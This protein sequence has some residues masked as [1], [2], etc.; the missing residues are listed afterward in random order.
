MEIGK[1]FR[2]YSYVDLNPIRAGVANTP[3]SSDFTSAQ[4]R[5]EARR[6]LDT[7]Q[8]DRAGPDAWLAPLPLEEGTTVPGPAASAA[9]HRYSDKGFVPMPL[10][11]YLALLDW[12]QGSERPVPFS[13]LG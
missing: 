10:S 9:Q 5:I 3:E 13:A 11:E 7:S 8:P 2:D 4:R 12:S 6:Q 1:L